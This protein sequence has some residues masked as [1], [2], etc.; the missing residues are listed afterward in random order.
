MN[1]MINLLMNHRS[2]RKFND[3]AVSDEV[4]TSILQ[5]AQ[6]APTSS[7]FQAYSI[8]HVVDPKKKAALAASAGDQAWVEKAPLVLLFCADLHRNQKYLVVKD[9]DILSNVESY[10]VGVTDAALAAQKAFIAAQ[11]HGLGG[12]IVGGVRNDMDLMKKEFELPDLVAP[13]FL[14]CLGYYDKEPLQRPRLPYEVVV[15]TDCYSE[16]NNAELIE[17]YN[18]KV[19]EFFQTITKGAEKFTWVETC[20]YNLSIKPR[21]EVTDYV[22]NAGF[23][24]K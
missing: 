19:S 2:V 1:E 8:I 5:C 10:T 3:K 22:K 24:Q 21:Y 17:G 9:E 11:C 18:Q 6:M 15:K 7:Y 13:L 16:E 4:R 14:L 23:L 12:V 20:S